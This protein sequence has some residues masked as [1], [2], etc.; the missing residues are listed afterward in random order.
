M[1]K[2][3]NSDLEN[4]KTHI[5]SLIKDFC[6]QKLNDEYYELSVKL[7]DKLGRKKNVPFMTGKI[8]VWAAAIIHAIGSVNF[9][10]DQSFKPFTTVDEINNFFGT[11]KSTTGN[12]SKEIRDLLELSFFINEF[13]T[14]H[15]IANN[16]MSNFGMVNG[17]IVK[18][19]D[20]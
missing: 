15:L 11:N 17:F 8:E 10:F 7:I 4:R 18:K 3:N 1:S 9:L 5:L 13:L 20:I 6:S 2:K 16:P 12:K 19:I 14:Q